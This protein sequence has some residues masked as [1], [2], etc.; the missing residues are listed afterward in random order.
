MILKKATITCNFKSGIGN[1]I[2]HGVMQ[3]YNDKVINNNGA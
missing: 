3:R 2:I 1:Y